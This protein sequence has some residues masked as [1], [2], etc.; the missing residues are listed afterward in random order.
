VIELNRSEGAGGAE[1]KFKKFGPLYYTNEGAMRDKIEGKENYYNRTFYRAESPVAHL[2]SPTG[3][4]DFNTEYENTEN[5]ESYVR[6]NS[7][8][9]LKPK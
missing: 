9:D 3:S 2:R 6:L 4:F 7:K 8:S 5:T 1:R